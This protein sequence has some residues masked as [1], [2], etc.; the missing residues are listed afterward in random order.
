MRY[1]MRV[2]ALAAS[3]VFLS[4]CGKVP[5]SPLLEGTPQVDYEWTERS[6]EQAEPEEDAPGNASEQVEASD[7]GTSDEDGFDGIAD[8]VDEVPFDVDEDAE[9]LR[10]FVDGAT[11]DYYPCYS[12]G[13]PG[14]FVMVSGNVANGDARVRLTGTITGDGVE[15][16][17]D[18]ERSLDDLAGAY[19]TVVTFDELS[20]IDGELS[21]TVAAVDEESSEESARELFDIISGS[22]NRP[23]ADVADANGL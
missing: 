18:V 21:V 23:S 7:V 6:S 15:T 5:L 20:G 17:Q 2:A 16:T 1:A 13:V 8:A 14:A 22:S 11:V 19:G 3:V 10:V 9:F 4:G 12:E